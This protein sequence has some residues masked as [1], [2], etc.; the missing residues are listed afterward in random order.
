MPDTPPTGP[1]LAAAFATAYDDDIRVFIHQLCE[2]S[3]ILGLPYSGAFDLSDGHFDWNEG[4]VV[5]N[6]GPG[7]RSVLIADVEQL[8]VVTIEALKEFCSKCSIRFGAYLPK[9]A[10]EPG[11][12]GR[13]FSALA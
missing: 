1:E 5:L 11:A 6:A 13:T 2:I 12:L 9:N 3:A 10:D 7:E 8:P 4:A